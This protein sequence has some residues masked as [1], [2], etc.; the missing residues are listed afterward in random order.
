MFDN[1]TTPTDPLSV[2]AEACQLGL[3]V[4]GLS[5]GA[6]IDG[7]Q[8]LA[9]QTNG[10]G[11]GGFLGVDLI[12]AGCL[13]VRST[14]W[15]KISKGPWF[16]WTTGDDELLSPQGGTGEDVFFCN[17]VRSAGFKIWT[18]R[19]LAGHYHSVDLTAGMKG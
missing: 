18:H 15:Q 8:R 17:L 7:K 16:K 11:V 9:T 12:G 13:M 1:D 5:Y 14:V 3:D 4:V 2:L 10:T 6:M 19:Q